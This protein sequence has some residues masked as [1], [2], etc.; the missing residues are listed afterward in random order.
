MHTEQHRPG[1]REVVSPYRGHCSQRRACAHTI[2]L[3]ID[4][5]RSLIPE[6]T[7]VREPDGSIQR[8]PSL[9]IDRRAASR[10]TLGANDELPTVPLPVV[11]V[12]REPFRTRRP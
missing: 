11:G 7:R 10:L 2:I 3:H 8:P 12:C 9:G 5:G 6:A 1:F 4:P